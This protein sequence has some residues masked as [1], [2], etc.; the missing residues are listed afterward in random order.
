MRQIIN[1]SKMGAVENRR[2]LSFMVIRSFY[3]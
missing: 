3:R 2:A 1:R